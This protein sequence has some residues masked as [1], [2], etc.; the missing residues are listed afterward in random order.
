MN[1]EKD[2]VVTVQPDP[3]DP[4]K[5][6]LV[7]ASGD[8]MVKVYTADENAKRFPEEWAKIVSQKRSDGKHIEFLGVGDHG[9]PTYSMSAI[10]G[11]LFH[12]TLGALTA[13]AVVGPQV[14][15][16]IETA[17]HYITVLHEGLAKQ[18]QEHGPLE[19]ASAFVALGYF[20]RF[21]LATARFSGA[22]AEVIG[23]L[24]DSGMVIGGVAQAIQEH[25][26]TQG[27]QDRASEILSA[28]EDTSTSDLPLPP[29]LDP[30]PRTNPIKIQV[31][32]GDEERMVKNKLKGIGQA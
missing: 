8:I 13:E 23:S 22:D 25:Q 26:Y 21:L 6:C 16:L 5:V 29:D 14:L 27:I 30:K 9:T 7:N 18:R 1:V 28:T 19:M 24:R 31:L 32:S 17:A 15:H 4:G 10:A 2:I 11:Y 12:A 3:L 20:S